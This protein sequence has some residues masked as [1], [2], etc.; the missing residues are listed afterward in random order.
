MSMCQIQRVFRSN[1][2]CQRPF[3]GISRIRWPPGLI[4]RHH[5]LRTGSN[6]RSLLEGGRSRHNLERCKQPIQIG[7][8][9]DLRRIFIVQQWTVRVLQINLYG[10]GNNRI[11]RTSQIKARYPCSIVQPDYDVCLF[12]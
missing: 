8:I 3:S 12:R 5:S 4:T 11:A 6:S 7:G 9:T 2:F 1:A 10:S